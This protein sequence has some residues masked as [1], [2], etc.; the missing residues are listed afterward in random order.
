[1][2]IKEKEERRFY[3]DVYHYK[4]YNSSSITSVEVLAK[5]ESD[6]RFQVL[7]DLDIDGQR[8]NFTVRVTEA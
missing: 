4:S 7:T 6:A 8:D 2:L 5:S 3:V 1:M